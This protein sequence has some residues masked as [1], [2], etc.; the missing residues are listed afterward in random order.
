MLQLYR[1]S[2][3]YKGGSGFQH[4]S[5]WVQR[6]LYASFWSGWSFEPLV[7]GG[8]ELSGGEP[9]NRV[10][11]HY[12]GYVRVS[13]CCENHMCYSLAKGIPI[14]GKGHCF[15]IRVGY[16]HPLYCGHGS[17]VYG[18]KTAQ[19]EIIEYL[20]MTA[21]ASWNGNLIPCDSLLFKLSHR[22]FEC[23]EKPKIPA[24]RTPGVFCISS[25]IIHFMPPPLFSKPI[26]VDQMVFHHTFWWSPWTRCRSF[27]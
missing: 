24:A 9:V 20:T 1:I 2:P 13:L 19:F 17:A 6:L 4:Q 7:A 16:L 18:V 27:P 3:G 14:P 11:V 25:Q 26:P 5:Q 12:Y 15:Q 23:A 22:F 21:D 8:G 10:V